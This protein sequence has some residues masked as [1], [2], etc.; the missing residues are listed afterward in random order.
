[1]GIEI[2]ERIPDFGILGR[3]HKDRVPDGVGDLAPVGGPD[4][5]PGPGHGV[6][7]LLQTV[8]GMGENLPGL[9]ASK[10][11]DHV[12]RAPGLEHDLGSVRRPFGPPVV[13]R[14]SR[15]KIH[16]ASARNL[17]QEDVLVSEGTRC[18]GQPITVR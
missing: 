17:P 6:H 12:D 3:G 14:K 2:E 5:A 18:V 11:R 7:C 8:A 10:S 1:V 4:G 9:H 13:A 16:G 15:R